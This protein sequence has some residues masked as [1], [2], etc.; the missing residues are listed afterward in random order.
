MRNHW[1]NKVV[2]WVTCVWDTTFFKNRSWNQVMKLQKNIWN[3]TLLTYSFSTLYRVNAAQIFV[4]QVLNNN[5]K[6]KK[7]HK[8]NTTLHFTFLKIMDKTHHVEQ[9]FKINFTHKQVHF[10]MKPYQTYKK[11]QKTWTSTEHCTFDH[12]QK[13]RRNPSL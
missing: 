9:I 13:H 3:Q 6:H 8:H 1:D 10:Q 2:N 7:K 4:R 12:F 11:T 5:E